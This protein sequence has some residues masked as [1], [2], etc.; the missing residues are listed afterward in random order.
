MVKPKREKP[1]PKRFMKKRVS[2][3]SENEPLKSKR[4]KQQSDFFFSKKGGGESSR[5]NGK[6]LG[7]SNE[8]MRAHHMFSRISNL[9]SFFIIFILQLREY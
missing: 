8:G 2:S 6:S 9:R 7:Q 3:D 4:N 1:K 5:R